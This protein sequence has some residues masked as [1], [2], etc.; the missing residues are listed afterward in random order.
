MA[1]RSYLDNR[2]D[3]SRDRNRSFSYTPNGR[4]VEDHDKLFVPYLDDIPGTDKNS[5]GIDFNDHRTD[6]SPDKEVFY[7]NMKQDKFLRQALEGIDLK[8]ISDD[9][10]AILLVW[11]APLVTSNFFYYNKL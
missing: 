9:E 7:E 11:T 8:E 2:D 6:L 4:K 10:F 1:N 5:K 3:L